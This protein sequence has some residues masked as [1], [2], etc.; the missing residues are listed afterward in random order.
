MLQLRLV[1]PAPDD[2][3]GMLNNFNLAAVTVVIHIS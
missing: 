2:L 1:G 3:G